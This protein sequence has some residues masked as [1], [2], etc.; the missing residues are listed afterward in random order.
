MEMY[1]HFPGS[2][3]GLSNSVAPQHMEDLFLDQH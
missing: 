2:L 1:P 3:I